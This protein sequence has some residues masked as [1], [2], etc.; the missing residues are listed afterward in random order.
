[1]KLRKDCAENPVVATRDILITPEPIGI[2]AECAVL[3]RD[4]D[5]LRELTFF[6]DQPPRFGATRRD[7]AEFL[8][9]LHP[10]NLS[11]ARSSASKVLV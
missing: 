11:I 7:G 9:R 2:P 5:H 10:V 4:E 3:I 1:M 8:E 6:D